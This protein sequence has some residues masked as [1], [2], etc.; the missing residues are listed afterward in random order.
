MLKNGFVSLFKYEL[1]SKF[2]SYK[3]ASH[4]HRAYDCSGPYGS[5][6]TY[7]LIQKLCF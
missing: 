5:L 2:K 7:D 3:L 4:V 6:G 1:Q